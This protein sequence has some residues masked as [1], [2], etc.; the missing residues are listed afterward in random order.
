MKRT[1]GMSKCHC[2]EIKLHCGESVRCASC[3][4]AVERER[5]RSLILEARENGAWPCDTKSSWP[6][7]CECYWCNR[8]RG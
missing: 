5:W 2:A 1:A 3:G 8:L 7:P 6:G 4:A